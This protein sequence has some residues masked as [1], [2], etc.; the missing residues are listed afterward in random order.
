L[1]NVQCT[2]LV[3]IRST[4]VNDGDTDSAIMSP[5]SSVIRFGLLL[6]ISLILASLD[7][8]LGHSATPS[9]AH[10]DTTPNM[11]VPVVAASAFW[12]R[13]QGCSIL[14]HP[15]TSS[16]F[17][18]ISTQMRPDWCSTVVQ[19]NTSDWTEVARVELPSSN[20]SVVG[21]TGSHSSLFA[22]ALWCHGLGLD[23]VC[24]QRIVG[25]DLAPLHVVS[26]VSLNI[27]DTLWGA[28]SDGRQLVT[29]SMGAGQVELRDATNGKVMHEVS[30]G[31][32][33][34]YVAGAAIT[35]VYSDLLI[36][37]GSVDGTSPALHFLRRAD[38]FTTVNWSLPLPFVSPDWIGLPNA[39]H[40]LVIDENDQYAFTRYW[41]MCDAG[42]CA[43]L[44]AIDLR[45]GSFVFSHLLLPA[46]AGSVTDQFTPGP[47]PLSFYFLDES[48][49]LYQ[50]HNATRRF[51]R[52][53]NSTY[54]SLTGTSTVMAVDDGVLVASNLGSV[55]AYAKLDTNGKVVL[56][57]ERASGSA[58][59][60]TCRE[61]SQTMALD[62]SGTV[63]LPHC[64]GSVI[65]Y[66]VLGRV[67]GVLTFFVQDD[68]MQSWYPVR[69]LAFSTLRPTAF[70]VSTDGLLCECDL[71]TGRMLQQLNVSLLSVINDVVVDEEDGSV[72]AVDDG[73][74]PA[75]YH[76]D[77]RGVRV[78]MFPFY[79]WPPSDT[80]DMWRLGRIA[81][82]P[83]HRRVIVS[84]VLWPG[85]DELT[86]SAHALFLDRSTGEVVQR[87]DYWG[88]WYS[89]AMRDESPVGVTAALDGSRVYVASR[90]FGGVYVVQPP[91]DNH[92][93]ASTPSPLH[94]RQ[95]SHAE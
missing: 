50:Q 39:L 18:A 92:T 27:S 66:G 28:T 55:L 83:I 13:H 95:A 23:F 73:D 40:V 31:L 42:E 37:D 41:T 34:L 71:H 56:S 82:D 33:T 70:V 76:F 8:I 30:G 74:L 25:V 59:S 3:I 36:A 6:A 5:Y 68:G 11:T 60:E 57:V 26:T 75:V 88:S 43:W 85:G 78:A 65:A 21:M 48:G 45:S 79:T 90:A 87:F 4:L 61:T 72:W 80:D 69:T 46:D 29:A 91:R 52:T 10:L 2:S 14:H 20:W 16:L 81:M 24:E 15:P 1:P 77:S 86:Q 89:P 19:F 94:S 35:P 67:V 93:T 38:G 51:L 32:S 22:Q 63:W 44:H 53:I 54:P 58:V 62:S 17:I 64:N 47:V 12:A 9:R 49:D 84:G 7:V